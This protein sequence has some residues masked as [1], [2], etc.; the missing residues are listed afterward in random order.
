MRRALF[1]VSLMIP[2]LA[3]ACTSEANYRPVDAEL[4]SALLNADDVPGVGDA[5]YP[6]GLR[7]QLASGE[8]PVKFDIAYIPGETDDGPI[9]VQSLVLVLPDADAADATMKA[10]ATPPPEQMEAYLAARKQQVAYEED[11]PAPLLGDQAAFGHLELRLSADPCLAAQG[12]GP[13]DASAFAPGRQFSIAWRQGNVL[14][15]VTT[16]ARP[17]A[18]DDGLAIRLARIQAQRLR[19][20]LQ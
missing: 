8:Q 16:L 4:R 18:G 15:Q 7:L 1:L 12:Q 17:P 10:R 5:V 11:L 14:G 19:A 13:T 2:L 20:I 3:A 9:C 6:E